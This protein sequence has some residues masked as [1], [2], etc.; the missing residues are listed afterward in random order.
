MGP[1]ELQGVEDHMVQDTTVCLSGEL[2]GLE[3]REQN[4][5]LSHL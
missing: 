4:R 1:A 3:S 5:F 2:C